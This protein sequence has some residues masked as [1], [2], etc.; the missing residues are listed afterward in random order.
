M[1]KILLSALIIAVFLA[2]SALKA[3]DILISGSEDYKPPRYCFGM[4]YNMPVNGYDDYSNNPVFLVQF[5]LPS[6]KLWQELHYR[7]SAEYFM[8][9]V[10]KDTYGITEDIFTFMAGCTY[11]VNSPKRRFHPFALVGLTYSFDVVRIKTDVLDTSSTYRYLGAK[12]SAGVKVDVGRD[13]LLFHELSLHTF[14]DG[15][16]TNLYYTLSIAI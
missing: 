5:D 9:W 4:G 11:R 2:V 7:F 8:M 1:K 16:A 6:R 3:E 12:V 15:F 10:P 13:S 14:F